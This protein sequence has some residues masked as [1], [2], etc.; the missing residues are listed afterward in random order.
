MNDGCK[1]LGT[2][3]HYI[4]DKTIDTGD[5]ISIHYIDNNKSLIG[6]VVNF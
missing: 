4:T 5:I 3:L 6:N 2:T 1:K